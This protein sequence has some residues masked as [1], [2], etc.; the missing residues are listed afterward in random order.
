MR[1]Y[2]RRGRQARVVLAAAQD[3][4]V[5]TRSTHDLIMHDG[6]MRER[7][8]ASEDPDAERA[9]WDGFVTGVRA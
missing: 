9:F 5:I 3:P 6:G 2:R 4:P 7:L 1:G 8:D